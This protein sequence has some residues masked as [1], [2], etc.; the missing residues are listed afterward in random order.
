VIGHCARLS[1]TAH[2]ADVFEQG[3]DGGQ[4]L[5]RGLWRCWP[6]ALPVRPLY[7]LDAPV[8]ASSM[9]SLGGVQGG[10]VVYRPA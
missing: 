4:D 2:M 7:A 9:P 3:G 8:K 5:A 6:P 10:Q 1:V